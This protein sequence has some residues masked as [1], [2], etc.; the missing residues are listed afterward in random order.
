MMFIWLFLGFN[1][2]H[3]LNKLTEDDRRSLSRVYVDTLKP[4]LKSS[5]D[6]FMSNPHVQQRFVEQ[7]MKLDY[8]MEKY[9]SRMKNE[10]IDKLK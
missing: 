8:L 1:L 5:F 4:D 10:S 6:Q 3:Q 2:G 9:D 7:R